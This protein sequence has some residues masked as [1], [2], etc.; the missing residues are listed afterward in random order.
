[1]I[2]SCSKEDSFDT[3]NLNTFQEKREW[4]NLHS[5]EICSLKT[6]AIILP[7]NNTSLEDIANF[8]ISDKDIRSMST[9]GLLETLQEWPSYRQGPWSCICVDLNLSG[10]TLFNR[11]LK[12][13]KIA[14]E[15]FGRRDCFQVLASKYQ[16]LDVLNEN[17]SLRTQF[18]E[19]L[20]AS[21]MCMTTLSKNEK[22]IF[23]VMAM[24]KGLSILQHLYENESLNYRF[25]SSFIIM[26]SVMKE[27][28]YS[29]FIKELK[30]YLTEWT[31]GY[32]DPR[33]GYYLLPREELINYTKQLLTEFSNSER[34]FHIIYSIK[35]E[36]YI[37]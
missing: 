10:V 33:I 1:M 25:N 26:I 22:I 13:N 17:N 24:E 2:I 36:R 34:K 23:L 4:L 7:E 11:G 32:Y 8:V 5:N 35:N 18:F 20:L 6:D 19:M 9:C 14:V 21:D 28:E 16:S 30:P 27:C 29:P 37:K 3:F 12:E 31:N 15:L